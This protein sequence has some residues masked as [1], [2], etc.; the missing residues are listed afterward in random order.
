MKRSL[1]IAA[2]AVALAS[3][4]PAA[5]QEGSKAPRPEIVSASEWGSKPQPIPDARKHTPKYVTIHHA[6]VLWKAQVTPDAFV[7]NMQGW[8]RRDKG[9]PDLAYHFLIA[10]DGKIY[11]GRS[12]DYEPESN[13][14]YPLAGNIGVEMMGNFEQ[15][16]PDPRQI[17]S[18]VKLTAWLCDRYGIDNALVRGHKDA[19]SGQTTC[20]GKDF[21]R[22]LKDGQFRRWVEETRAGKAPEIDPGPPLPGGP[23]EMIPSAAPPK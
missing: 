10:P 8:G 19:A 22:Y 7:R 17:A 15:Q 13:T 16:R 14:K 1:S 18:C 2:I 6:G 5:E 4:C 21:E 3:P 9:W 20:P 23:T 12:L 11:E